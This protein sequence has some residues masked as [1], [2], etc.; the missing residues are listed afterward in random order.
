M[1]VLALLPIRYH[2]PI[3]VFTSERKLLEY[4]GTRMYLTADA[5][6]KFFY[7]VAGEEDY[8]LAES[9]LPSKYQLKKTDNIAGLAFDDE[10]LI[11]AYALAKESESV[12]KYVI[13]H[14]LGHSNDKKNA[15]V[16]RR[17]EFADK[18]ALKWLKS[19]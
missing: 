13:L 9:K 7:G 5:A 15:S 16:G 8:I 6:K 14:E 11:N 3:K 17:E 19:C 12:V 2:R 18:F 10:I 4:A 1:E